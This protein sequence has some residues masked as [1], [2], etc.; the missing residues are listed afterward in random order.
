MVMGIRRGQTRILTTICQWEDISHDMV[1]DKQRRES[2]LYG[3]D[4]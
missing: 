2:E 4:L 3:F 1:Q